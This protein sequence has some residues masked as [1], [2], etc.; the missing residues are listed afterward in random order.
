MTKGAPVRDYTSGV[1][2]EESPGG[3]T[4]A[5][6]PGT[7]HRPLVLGSDWAISLV[8][9]MFAVAFFRIISAIAERRLRGA[10]R[11]DEKPRQRLEQ[12]RIGRQ[13]HPERVVGLRR[14]DQRPAGRPAAPVR[15][16]VH[17][18]V[19]QLLVVSPTA[20]A[21]RR[22]LEQGVSEQLRG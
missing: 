4:L 15:G 19:P 8:V 18:I 7:P 11:A 10:E 21:L 13:E 3:G 17:G 6:S 12:L 1:A 20:T 16:A 14:D 2:L 9:M 5:R 22:S